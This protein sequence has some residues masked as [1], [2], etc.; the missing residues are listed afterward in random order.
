MIWQPLDKGTA[1]KTVTSDYDVERPDHTILVD[2]SSG[3]ITVTLLRPHEAPGRR[4]YIMK[5]DSSSNIVTVD[6]AGTARTI[7]GA[8]SKALSAQFDGIFV[9]ADPTTFDW[10]VVSSTI[11]GGVAPHAS[12]HISGASDE[13]DGDQ[14]DIDYSPTNYTQDTSPAE[15]SSTDHL[16]A[17][18]AGIDNKLG[19]TRR[20]PIKSVA[21][22]YTITLADWTIEAD[23]SGGGF[24]VTLPT[25]ASAYDGPAGEGYVFNIVRTN[26]GGN[27]VTLAADGAETILTPSG[28]V[29]TIN[30]NS[31]AQSYTVQSNGTSWTI[32]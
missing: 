27:K 1:V 11:G 32:L 17:H 5:V 30:L 23:A 15:V 29:N 4:N 18:L 16:T 12:T 31:R 28:L 25:A 26:S 14:L 6:V 21:A 2:A 20:K 13:I 10:K 8:A 22:A 19:L 24:T 7:N 9:Q 3:P